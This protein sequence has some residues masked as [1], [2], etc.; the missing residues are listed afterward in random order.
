MANAVAEAAAHAQIM[1]YFR[2][3]FFHGEDE[4]FDSDNTKKAKKTKGQKMLLEFFTT[5][6]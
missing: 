3:R 5:T 4:S 6:P 1:L 2:S